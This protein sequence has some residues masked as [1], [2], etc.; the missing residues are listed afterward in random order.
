MFEKYKK[1]MF[2]SLVINYMSIL[3]HFFLRIFVIG[4]IYF[5]HI[6]Y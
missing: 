4:K 3:F 5:F 1:F 2:Y 6:L